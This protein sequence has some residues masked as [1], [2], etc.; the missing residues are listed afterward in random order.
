VPLVLMGA[1]VGAGAVALVLM[2]MRGL[3]ETAVQHKVE[4]DEVV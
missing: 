1:T 3:L 2:V 4:L